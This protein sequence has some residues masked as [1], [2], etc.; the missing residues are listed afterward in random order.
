M[1]KH[2][3]IARMVWR[4]AKVR[5]A[6]KRDPQARAY[7]DTAL[8]PVSADDVDELEMFR[9]TEAARG[10]AAKVRRDAARVAARA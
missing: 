10:A 4:L 8:T 1:A 7:M 3:R 6:I 9:V 2:V 5:R